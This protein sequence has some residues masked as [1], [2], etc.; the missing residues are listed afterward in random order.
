MQALRFFGRIT[1]I[2]VCLTLP[3]TVAAGEAS[4]QL[5]KGTA[6][7]DAGKYLL[8]QEVL[9]G[10][11]RDALD[12]DQKVLRDE[13][14][15]R[16]SVAITMVGKANQ[17]YDD[18]RD[19]LAE[20]QLEQADVLFDGVL[21]N[22]YASATLRRDAEEGLRAV[23]AQRSQGQERDDLHAAPVTTREMAS[24]V[25]RQPSAAPPPP[26]EGDST[27]QARV[28]TRRGD[29]ALD[30]GKHDEAA[31]LFKQA[32]TVVPGFPE[33]VDGIQRVRAHAMV[34]SGSLDLVDEINHRNLIRW[35]RVVTTYRD[36]EAQIREHVMANRFDLAKQAVLR[37]RQT[38]EAGKEFARPLARYESLRAEV[39]ALARFVEDEARH[40]DELQ[41]RQIREDVAQK[42]TQ[43]RREE[44]GARQR[45]VDTLMD[46]A[47]QQRK[48]RNYEASIDILRQ[49]VNIDPR[50]HQARWMLDVLEDE[51][52]F[53][54]QRDTDT[55]RQ[56][57]TQSILAEVQEASIPWHRNLTYPKNWLEIISRPDR[58]V[59]GQG[60]ISP[61]DQII[62]RKLA[63][64]IPVSFDETPFGE[65]IETVAD[66]QQVNITV[67]WSDLAN[68][69]IDEDTPV[70]LI[71]PEEITF[72]R[73]LEET[74]SQLG[75]G[76]VE[77]GYVVSE[78]II[79]IATRDLLDR[80]VFVQV[81]DVSD[82]LMR[83]PDFADAP[84][85]TLE[86]A[87]GGSGPGGGTAS[88]NPFQGGG[89]GGGGGD[90]D[91]RSREERAE[92]IVL[93]IRGTIEPESWREAGGTDASI[94]ALEASL[95][96]A[97]TSSGH[98][99]IADLLSQLREERTVQIAVEARFLTVTANYL[100]EMG[101]DLDIILNQGN[102]G[103]DRV[104]GLDDGTAL[105][106]PRS[107]SR[108]GF[109][110][111]VPGVGVA[112]D[113]RGIPTTAVTN[114]RQPYGNV[115]LV[116]QTGSFMNSGSRM[117]PI[118]ILNDV[119]SITQTQTTSIPGSLGGLDTA[120]VQ[121]F[122][123][124]LD[125]IQ[126]DFMLRATQA[127]RRSSTMS[128]PRLVLFNGQRAWVGVLREQAY[129]S[130]VQPVVDETAVAQQPQTATILS[131]A[132]LDVRATV[133]AD[134]KYITMDLLPSVRTLE[135]IEL[136]PYSGGAAGTAAGGGFIQLPTT[137]SQVIRTTV[138][139]PDGGT[140]LIGGMKTTEEVEVEAGV[141]VLSKIPVLKR[142]YSNRSLVKDETVLLIL[143]KPTIIITREAEEQA[144]PTFG[145]RG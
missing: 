56:K 61:E 130:D 51:W 75:G 100:E 118:P 41:V 145:S 26:V 38:V 39:D 81:Y 102:A 111:A 55:T 113:P 10:I 43:R 46:Q 91:E 99:Q 108:M 60:Y 140:L 13:Y 135:G 137:Q 78:G 139:V 87:S 86:Q 120:A 80:D 12:D 105:L 103:Y 127:D 141:P 30:S 35:Q 85:V 84:R 52:A 58:V 19:A 74:L 65:V 77:L 94:R 15:D 116:P 37:A 92:D 69:A 96:V 68:H 24:E 115:G 2:L 132:V 128:A 18:A 16:I 72:R 34:E 48:D 117:T 76:A 131:G 64:R 62:S 8:A 124:F 98:E 121:I 53:L 36:T 125:N 73:A 89:G 45:R 59:S 32:L 67:V 66:T 63:A 97:Q 27:A 54:R 101:I 28:L 104:N 42:D 106:L 144:F 25:V 21:E 123:S 3:V 122:G 142:L 11:D 57:Q 23:G 109:S 119:L 14:V 29:R 88:Q 31:A 83:V 22:E 90:L 44:R 126:V 136:F 4:E 110:P 1:A 143:V 6:L 82:L 79:K 129:V 17:D 50:N 133:S 138:K 5:S 47:A 95:I 71:L 114:I 40:Y 9:L 134:K 93:L 20:G 49:V 107:F 7:F 70:T 112:L 33:A